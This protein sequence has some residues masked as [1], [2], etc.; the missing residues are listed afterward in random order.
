MPFDRGER[1]VVPA[2]KLHADGH[3]V[4]IT[5]RMPDRRTLDTRTSDIYDIA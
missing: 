4:M 1:A 5:L 2:Q 3:R